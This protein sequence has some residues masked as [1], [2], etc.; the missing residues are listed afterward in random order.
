MTPS[1]NTIIAAV[2]GKISRDGQN[3]VIGYGSNGFLRLY[4]STI[5]LGGPDLPAVRIDGKLISGN[6]GAQATL[7]AKLRTAG[8]EIR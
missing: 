7:R 1:L 3:V 2:G 5:T 6:G 4:P 8:L